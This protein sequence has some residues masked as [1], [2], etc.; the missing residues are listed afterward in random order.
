[1][2]VNNEILSWPLGVYVWFVEWHMDALNVITMWS[3]AVVVAVVAFN[4]NNVMFVTDVLDIAN[5][6]EWPWRLGYTLPRQ[7]LF[8]SLHFT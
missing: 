4:P 1:M 7:S 6:E 2:D 3:W 5:D 8:L